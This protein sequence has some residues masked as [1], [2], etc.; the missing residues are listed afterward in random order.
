M[1]PTV[2]YSSLLL[3]ALALCSCENP[4]LARKRDKQALEISRLKGELAMT[5]EQLKGVPQDRSEEFIDIQ[6]T[7]KKQQEELSA[8]EAEV[9]DLELKKQAIEKE[10]EDYKAKYVIR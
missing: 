1:K 2:F 3:F 5:E 6:A 8:L 4:E 9:A 10:F 7:A